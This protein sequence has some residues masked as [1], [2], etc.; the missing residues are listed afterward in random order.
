MRK[1]LIRENDVP[2]L[3]REEVGEPIDN[4]L[5]QNLIVGLLP[6]RRRSLSA[7]LR[8]G[9][10]L[11]FVPF[12]VR[13]PAA[14][15]VLLVLPPVVLYAHGSL[16]LSPS[17]LLPVVCRQGDQS[18]RRLRRA[19]LREGRGLSSCGLLVGW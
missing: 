16:Y 5:N 18:Q 6:T 1:F 15:G 3:T 2:G 7:L 4:M 17:R 8:S 13:A 9:T 14:S 12:L 11:R 19:R 10:A